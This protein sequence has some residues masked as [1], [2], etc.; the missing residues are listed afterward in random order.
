MKRGRLKKMFSEMVYRMRTVG[1]TPVR[2]A[3]ALGIGVFIGSSPWFG[4]HLGLCLV[5]SRLLGL[6]PVTMYAGAQI[7][8]PIFAPFLYYAELQVGTWL[9][10]G[11]F[12][13]ITLTV[14]RGLDH[15]ELVSLILLTLRDVVIGSLVVGAVL[16]VAFGLAGFQFF[17]SRS[18]H[19]DRMRIAD[20]VS[21]RYLESSAFDWEY[22][23]AKLRDDPVYLGILERKLLPDE[24]LLV[25]VGCGRG[26]L[27]ALVREARLLHKDG[28]WPA[29]WPPPP[30]RIKLHG[31]ER[32]L[33]RAA[34]AKTAL[35]SAARIEISP[36]ALASVPRCTA[37]ALIDAL[38]F[39]APAEQE[40]LLRHV[41]SKL[42][43]GGVVLLR[44]IDT[45]PFRSFAYSRL[46][47]RAFAVARWQP[48]QRIRYRPAG[49]WMHVLR[50]L[51]LAPEIVPLDPSRWGSKVFIVARK[52]DDA[53]H[54]EDTGAFARPA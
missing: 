48:F 6:S 16:G 35:G 46:L 42:A 15:G 44:E 38:R 23:R 18:R 12:M 32:R 29:D 1:E 36:L 24:G 41:A 2:Q 49:E 11:E 22:A 10:T 5:A 13:D 27:L 4:A 14:M 54:P 17:N 21:R 45:A 25:D 8:Y 19:P 53:E 33:W 30:R 26:M 9:R 20:E 7:S 34:A 31:I 39:I 43:P 40:Q 50:E 51:G 28:G 47:E 37:V 52:P 3:V